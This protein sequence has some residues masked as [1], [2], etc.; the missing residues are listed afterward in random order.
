[1]D[2]TSA[3]TAPTP[4]FD[5][6]YIMQTEI[7]RVCILIINNKHYYLMPMAV[8]INLFCFAVLFSHMRKN[9]AYMLMGSIALWDMA[10]IVVKGFDTF[11]G[12][13]SWQLGDVGCCIYGFLLDYIPQV[14]IWL[15]VLLTFDR[16]IAVWFPLRHKELCSHQRIMLAYVGI[17]GISAIPVCN[18]LWALQDVPKPTGYACVFKQQHM[19]VA[20]GLKWVYLTWYAYIPTILMIVLNCLL[21]IKMRHQASIFGD[22]KQ[23]GNTIGATGRIE[24]YVTRMAF[25]VSISFVVLFVPFSV[26]N[27]A[28]ISWDHTK[29]NKTFLIYVVEFT[30]VYLLNDLNHIANPVLYFFSGR[31]FRRDTLDLLNKCICRRSNK[32]VVL[33]TATISLSMD[34]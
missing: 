18:H 27:V 3:N 19:P 22:A 11:I 20:T 1:M 14:T 13:Y 31:R 8:V 2:V 32:N 28:L 9:T 10:T 33:T 4:E 23:T 34:G 6:Q 24:A 29:S 25:L 5:P 17:M 15:V 16:C 7:F 26:L 21:A 30:V 12:R